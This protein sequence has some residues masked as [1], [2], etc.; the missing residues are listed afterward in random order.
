MLD[1][2]II[3]VGKIKELYW[4]DAIGEYLKRLKP[5]CKLTFL[6]VPEEKISS[7][8]DRKRILDVE[9]ERLEKILPND[10]YLVVLD[11]VGVNVSS[12]EFAKKLEG[13]S[14][15]GKRITFVIG[16]P[17]G[18]SP[19]IMTRAKVSLSLSHMTFTH[20]MVRVI[21]IEQIYR[22]VSII[23]GKAYHY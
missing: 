2:G 18:L 11:S 12:E 21:L 5:Y 20:Q 14:Y 6:E 16:G 22:A 23:Q 13:W 19:K 8:T 3:S 10:T 1:I 15:Y 9:G 4:Q 7:V 17:L